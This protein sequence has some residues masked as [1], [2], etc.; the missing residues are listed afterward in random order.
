MSSG[1]DGRAKSPCGSDN[2]LKLVLSRIYGAQYAM[3]NCPTSPQGNDQP[4]FNA[5]SKTRDISPT[6]QHREPDRGRERQDHARGHAALA[7]LR[8]IGVL[9]GVP[10][11]QVDQLQVNDEADREERR[12]RDEHGYPVDSSDMH[13]RSSILLR[14]KFLAAAQHLQ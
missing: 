7:Q 11:L 9:G 10:G 8:L 5:V 13:S 3:N 12:C 14:M 1:N 2:S 6:E 4:P